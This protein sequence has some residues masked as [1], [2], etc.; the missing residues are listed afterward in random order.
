MQT[1][2][3]RAWSRLFEGYSRRGGTLVLLEDIQWAGASL[4]TLIAGVVPTLVGPV[5]HIVTTRPGLREEHPD[6][7]DGPGIDWLTLPPLDAE[8]SDTLISGLLGGHPLASELRATIISRAE[9]NPFFL[10]ETV[11]HVVEAGALE[12]EGTSWRASG[13]QTSSAIPFS[14]ASVLSARIQ[15]LPLDERRV[16]QEAAVVGRTFWEGTLHHVLGDADIAGK[17]ERLSKRGLISWR[18]ESTLPGQV[19]WQFKHVLARD[20][21]YD[22]LSA[23]RRARSHAA[24][25]AWL[26]SLAPSLVD[27]VAEMVAMHERTAVESDDG[28][29]WDPA[30]RESIRSTAFRH[31][32]YAGDRARQRSAFDLAVELT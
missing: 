18:E 5:M 29:V 19:E 2:I 23:R 22:T 4:R 3:I 13:D 12:R 28:G 6:F 14:L 25:G 30:E 21:A 1:A 27:E 17:L 16:L 31:L 8:A 24:V 20:A 9:G 10:E 26:A 11:R 32:M 15:A 7:L